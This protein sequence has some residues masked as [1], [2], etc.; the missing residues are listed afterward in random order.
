[1]PPPPFLCIK[2]VLS[3]GLH[4][5]LNQGVFHILTYSYRI[6][7]VISTACST[8]SAY[9]ATLLLCQVCAFRFEITLVPLHFAYS[10]NVYFLVQT[11]AHKKKWLLLSSCLAY[12]M[13]R[14]IAWTSGP[15]CNMQLQTSFFMTHSMCLCLHLNDNVNKSTCYLFYK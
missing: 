15:H 7:I 6:F 3:T 8:H 12:Q 1:M 11:V 4:I 2:F 5:T 13:L 10:E 9:C 14:L